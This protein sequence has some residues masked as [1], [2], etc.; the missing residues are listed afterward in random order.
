MDGLN[1]RFFWWENE[2]NE[3]EIQI[4]IHSNKYVCMYVILNQKTNFVFV[5]FCL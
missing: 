2:W 4:F 1:R 5:Y 3:R